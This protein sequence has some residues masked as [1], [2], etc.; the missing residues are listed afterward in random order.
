MKNDDF[1]DRMKLYEQAEA[2]RKLLPLV[3]VCARLDGKGFS[4]FTRGLTRPFDMGMVKAMVE[5]TKY[6]VEETNARIGY[7][8]SDEISLVFYSDS[9]DSEIFFDGKVQ[10]LVSTLAAMGTAKFNSLVP[11]YLPS[12]KGMLPTF[13]CRVWSVPNKTEAANTLLWREKDAT[14]NSISMAAQHYYSH[15]QLHEKGSSEKQELLHQKGVNWNDYPACFKRG[16][17]VQRC[18]KF[19]TLTDEELARIPERHRPPADQKVERT[20]VVELDMPPF[21][22]VLNREAV[23]F[24]G[25]APESA[26]PPPP[27]VMVKYAK[28]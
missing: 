10:K 8:Q 15:N 19:V 1:G 23:V 27:L 22:K 4:K 24:D 3:P 7:T 20:H 25:A 21:G 28:L 18:K 5:T 12:K 11:D 17:F 9:F 13:D 6:L 16:T 26:D 14:K 2:G